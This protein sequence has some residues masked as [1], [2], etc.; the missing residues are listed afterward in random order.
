MLHLRRLLCRVRGH[1]WGLWAPSVHRDADGC[2]HRS[3]HRFCLRCGRIDRH[4]NPAAL[5][6]YMGWTATCPQCNRRAVPCGYQLGER[7]IIPAAWLCLECMADTPGE[8]GD[9]LWWLGRQGEAAE[10]I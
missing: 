5:E 7:G 2:V 9:C 4:P 10:A 6:I 1:R 3:H 8:F